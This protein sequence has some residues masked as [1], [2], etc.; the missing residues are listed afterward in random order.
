MS[1]QGGIPR[2]APAPVLRRRGWAARPGAAAAV[3]SP[4]PTLHAARDLMGADRV[5]IAGGVRPLA[6]K[7]AGRGPWLGAGARAFCVCWRARLRGGGR[8][9]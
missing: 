5:I 7:C 2:Y 4:R 8:A 9:N 3:A 6:A 1:W